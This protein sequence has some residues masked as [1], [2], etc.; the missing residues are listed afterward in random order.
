MDR[1][2]VLAEMES[3]VQLDHQVTQVLQVLL[4]TPVEL[5]MLV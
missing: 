4:E 2:E 3:V 5:V 1:Q